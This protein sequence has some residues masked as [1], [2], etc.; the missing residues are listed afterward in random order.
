MKCLFSNQ[1]LLPCTE[2]YLY[3]LMDVCIRLSREFVVNIISNWFLEAANHTCG[4]FERGVDE[5]QLSGLT[6][7]PS[8]LIKPPRVK[9]AAVQMECKLKHVYETHDRYCCMLIHSNACHLPSFRWLHMC[10]LCNGNVRYP[11][12]NNCC[13]SYHLPLSVVWSK[14]R[15]ACLVQSQQHKLPAAV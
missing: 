7:V 2:G 5:M 12:P 9:E 10:R 1:Q 8:V 4:E 13:V 11:V 14:C 3:V 15:V 6:A